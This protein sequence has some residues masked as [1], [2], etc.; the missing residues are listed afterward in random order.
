MTTV[1]TRRGTIDLGLFLLRIAL[2]VWL[3]IQATGTFFTLG[4]HEGIAGLESDFAAYSQAH[5]LAIAVP[6]VQLAAGI[7]LLLGLLAP[8]AAMLAWIVTGFLVVHEIAQAQTGLNVF[9]WEE[10]LWVP[11]MAAVLALV[12]QFTGPGLYALDGARG[13]ARRPLASS[14]LFM[15]LGIAAVVAAWWLLAGTNPLSA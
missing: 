10:T 2:S 14:W 8:V 11:V 1:D 3:I 13:W 15:I 7:F 4:A 5:L 12:V 9:N 6:S